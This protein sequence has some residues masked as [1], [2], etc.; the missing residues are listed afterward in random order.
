MTSKPA[1]AKK[2]PP[3]KTATPTAPPPSPPPEKDDVD[4]LLEYEKPAKRAQLGD[5]VDFRFVDVVTGSLLAGRGVVVHVHPGVVQVAPLGVHLI[6]VRD[7]VGDV[8]VVDVAGG[9]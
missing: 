9:G 6:D 8:Q 2:R 3:A 5:V 1:P 4:E 7:D